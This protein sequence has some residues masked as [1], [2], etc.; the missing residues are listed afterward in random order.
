M[1]KAVGRELHM[2]IAS[3]FSR[4]FSHDRS[5]NVA[6]A[7]GI[8]LIPLIGLVGA[9]V[10]YSRASQARTHLQR[11]VDAA[12]L[13]S[14]SARI[15][16]P[17]ERSTI[18]M[19]TVESTVGKSPA[20]I[21]LKTDC[22]EAN[23]EITVTA[24]AKI[25]NTLIRLL[26]FE[27]TTISALSQATI[28]AGAGQS[29][30]VEIAL[31]LDTTGS[32]RN[33]MVA[34]R[35]SAR[36]LVETMFDA[37]SSDHLRVAVVPYVATVN[38]GAN[39]LASSALDLNANSKWHGANFKDYYVA[40]LQGCYWWNTFV[41]SDG[42]TGDGGSPGGLG[43]PSGSDKSTF[44]GPLRTIAQISR[45]LFGVSDARADVT[46]STRRPLSGST[47]TIEP[48]Y[49]ATPTTV[50]VPTGFT[51]ENQCFLRNP[52]KVSH[53]DLF[54]RIPNARWKGCVEARPDPF[55]V[56]D[57][58]PSAISPDTLFV[59][60]FYPDDT[61][62]V[63]RPNN[64]LPDG[65]IPPGFEWEDG[66]GTRRS[67]IFK[68]D[69]VT[70][71]NLQESAPATRGPNA[72]CPDEMLQLTA[73][74][75]SV[76]NRVA[77]LNYWE[78]GGTIT[79]EG[80]AWGWRALSPRAPLGR[81]KPYGTAEKIMVVMSDGRNSLIADGDTE[82]DTYSEYTAYG[83][84]AGDRFPV[85]NFQAAERLLDDRMNLVCSNAKQAGIKIYSV[86]F[87]EPSPEA[88]AA[89]SKCATSP[90]H[91]Y[92]AADQAALDSAFQTIASRIT[93]V[94]LSR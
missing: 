1:G 49:V 50:V 33:D 9:A 77:T 62:L 11:A 41:P 17:S 7:F 85:N 74:R 42:G 65:I 10:D 34:L 89:M 59:P 69:T 47:V 53:F 70:S 48:P 14:A 25:E 40:M 71:A 19:R 31:V 3:S 64:Y 94:R 84:L 36:R 32:M 73:D 83:N 63:A 92:Y 5:G 67:N 52:P 30:D 79:S 93:Q 15:A 18:A 80:V 46:P 26:G 4:R 22:K 66:Q 86:L 29:S 91:F 75:A 78:S 68:Y 23:A 61:D 16:T 6:L 38:V 35:S 28:G 81:G 54:N 57:E 87:R 39:T 44:L 55:D 13:A 12:A 43:A 45:E 90:A 60:Y 8:A 21:D 24:S 2:R 56:T 76:L 51:F 88:R 20:M 27:R 82:G 58:P 37:L 72:G